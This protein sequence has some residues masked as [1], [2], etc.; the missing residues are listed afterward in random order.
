ME[1]GGTGSSH[2]V[3]TMTRPAGAGF[4]QFFPAAPRAA[5]D[6]ATERE[7]AKAKIHEST[8]SQA[9]DAN[10]RHAPFEP[11]VFAQADH[12]FL[13]LASSHTNGARPEAAHPPTDDA[14]SVSGETPFPGG[15]A[16]SHGSSNSSVFSAPTRPS[17]SAAVRLSS[18][19]LSPPTTIGSP[20]SCLSITAP[21]KAPSTTPRP[22][23][24][25]DKSAAIPNGSVPDTTAPLPGVAERVPA[26]DPSRP[27][28]CIK[29]IYDPVLDTSLSS[30]ER[31]KAKP[32]YKEYGLV[33]EPNTLTLRGERHLVC[34]L[35][36]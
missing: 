8:C 11:P 31:R 28:Q 9:V 34:E 2:P 23:D 17:A 36:G 19:Q 16:S 24:A 12:A 35:I 32:L 26:R 3:L 15:S 5:R 27:I 30:S 10:G 22:A 20:S 14:D 18:S 21:I 33:C 1:G 29:C 4:A 25:T 13:G 6:R 7:R